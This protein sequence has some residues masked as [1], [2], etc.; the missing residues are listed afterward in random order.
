MFNAISIQIPMII[1]T[2]IEKCN[3][4]F[5]WKHKRWLRAKE[6]LSKKRKAGGVTILD[7][8]LYNRVIAIKTAWYWQKNRYEDQWNRRP[9][10]K[11]THV[12]QPYF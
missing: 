7:L 1:I 8:K 11:S 10:N 9:R 6:I 5:I 4:K 3:L 2:E 12:C